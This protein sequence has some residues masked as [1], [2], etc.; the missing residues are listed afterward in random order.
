VEAVMPSYNENNGGIP[1]H[2]N[3][4]LLKDILRKEWG[5]TGL[6]VSDYMGVEQLAGLQHVAANNDAAGVLAFKSGVD[7]E[8]PT[9]SG[10]PALVAAVKDGKLPEKSLDEAV[11]RVLTAKFRAGIFE[12]PYVDEDRAAAEVG[13]KEHAK[14]GR[15]VADEAI[16]LL[17]NKGNLLPLDPSKIKT[18]AVIGPNGKKER[19][20]TY[21][22]LPPYYVSVFDGIQKRAGAGTNVV[23]AEGCRISEPDTAP[24]VNAFMPYGAPKED[25]DQKLLQEAL[26]T[27]KSADVIV[28]ALGVLGRIR[29]LIADQ[30]RLGG[31][32][33]N[34]IAVAEPVAIAQRT[35]ESLFVQP[36]RAVAHA[37]A[38]MKTLH[39]VV[40]VSPTRHPARVHK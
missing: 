34:G 25:T 17:Q 31:R 1:S 24:N 5:F 3:T 32:H 36:E 37:V 13:N 23:F 19:L 22:G 38:R 12:H 27:A 18:L 26:E 14:L 8:L 39:H 33:Q 28:L 6:T 2:A 11:G 30:E 4:W 20:G 10:Y 40:G 16:V 21:S 9:A 29:V 7:M 35:L 15:Q